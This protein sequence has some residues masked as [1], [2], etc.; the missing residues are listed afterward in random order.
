MTCVLCAGELDDGSR[1]RRF[2][3]REVAFCNPCW[4][5]LSKEV[6]DDEADE[7]K[8]RKQL[9]ADLTG[10]Q[11]IVVNRCHGGFDLSSEAIQYYLDLIGQ[12]YVLVDRADRDSTR[13]FGQRVMVDGRQFNESRVRRDDPALV[14]TVRDLGERVNTNHSNVQVIEIP[15]NVDW[16]IE[17][18][19]GYEKLA[20]VHRSW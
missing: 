12:P 16:E 13:R 4:I 15:A 11:Y 6:S 20:E 8:Q 1:H 18:Y 14:K 7:V 9:F 19:D 5:E 17:E 10:Y 2:G 3:D